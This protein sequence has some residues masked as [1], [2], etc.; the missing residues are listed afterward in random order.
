MI[1]EKNIESEIALR[2]HPSGYVMEIS[3]ENFLVTLSREKDLPN[4]DIMVC[5]RSKMAA[6][7]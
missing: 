1:T 2:N 6:I 4:R 5:K 3:V 7:K